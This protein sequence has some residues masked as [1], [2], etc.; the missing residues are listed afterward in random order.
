[1]PENNYR[2]APDQDDVYCYPGTKVLKNRFHIKNAEKLEEIEREITGLKIIQLREN[3]IPGSFDISHLQSIHRFIF[4][5]IFE[6]AGTL[7][8]AGFLRKGESIFCLGEYILPSAAEIHAKLKQENYLRGMSQSVFIERLALYM[9]EINALHPFR[10]GNGRTQREY[11]YQLSK[12]AGYELDFSRITTQ[13]LLKADIAAYSG[14]FSKLI[15][16]LKESVAACD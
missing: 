8:E 16:L 9:G 15:L 10:E 5:D 2:Y 4:E 6:W 13:A 7:R 14:D 11:F 3:P 1:M 12:Q